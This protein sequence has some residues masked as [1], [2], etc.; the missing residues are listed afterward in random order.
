MAASLKD[1]PDYISGL[2]DIAF[3]IYQNFVE[4]KSQWGR[5]HHIK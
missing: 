4:G 2:A 1:S 3:N 5:S